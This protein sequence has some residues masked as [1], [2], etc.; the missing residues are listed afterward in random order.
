[1]KQF[2]INFCS[3][4]FD[5]FVIVNTVLIWNITIFSIALGEV[6]MF[7]S[8]SQLVIANIYTLI[9]LALMIFKNKKLWLY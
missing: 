4:V 7:S 2:L 6:I 3:I 8:T 5:L 9:L 1:M